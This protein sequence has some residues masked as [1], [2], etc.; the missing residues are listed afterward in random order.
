LYLDK[1]YPE[2]SSQTL[3][4]PGTIGLT[5]ALN[6]QVDGLFTKYVA[7]ADQMR[8]DPRIVERV[9]EIFAKRAGGEQVEMSDADREKLMVQFEN[10]L[11]EF[12]KAYYHVGGTT[13][14]FWLA[15]GTSAS[16]AQ[17]SAREVCGPYL[18][19]DSPAYADLIVGAWL[20]MMEDCMRP[21]DWRRA[22]T[23]QDGFWARLH[24]ALAPLREMV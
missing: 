19:G 4:R 1:T 10:A 3:F 16:Q 13:D 18:D 2:A 6:A 20:A 12:V 14:Y 9:Q 7:L 11:G 22:R 21:E 8:F 23:W 5:A 15:S 17:S 24:D